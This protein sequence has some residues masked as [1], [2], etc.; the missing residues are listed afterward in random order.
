MTTLAFQN[1]VK[2]NNFYIFV[3]HIQAK[4]DVLFEFKDGT[5]MLQY[6]SISFGR[7]SQKTFEN[8]V[9]EQLPIIYEEVI[10]GLYDEDRAND[11]IENIENEFEIY[12]SKL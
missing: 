10:H 6:H 5:K 12:L 11:I 9:R 3:K 1:A 8:Y 7:M 4:Y 2:R